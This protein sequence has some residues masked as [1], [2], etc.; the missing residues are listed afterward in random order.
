MK[1][2][3][4]RT[5][6]AAQLLNCSTHVIRRLCESRLV[7][8]ELSHSNQWRVPLSEIE[9]LKEEG[10]PPL[11]QLPAD[12]SPHSP[13]PEKPA[14]ASVPASPTPASMFESDDYEPD[15]VEMSDPVKAELSSLTVAETRLKRRRIEL[16]QEEVED[17]FRERQRREVE[18]QKRERARQEEAATKEARKRWAD[19]WVT[20]AMTQVPVDCPP[21]LRLK[22]FKN[23][24][25]LMSEV[26]MRQGADVLTQIVS[27]AVNEALL[28][29]LRSKEVDRAVEDALSHLPSGARSYPVSRW[30]LTAKKQAYE[31]ISRL[32]ER[33]RF[34]EMVTAARLAIEPTIKEFEHHDAKEALLREMSFWRTWEATSEEREQATRTVRKALDSTDPGCTR[35][36]LQRVKKTALA[37]FE[38]TIS[39]RIEEEKQ[40]RAVEDI[41]NSNL[42]RLSEYLRTD[43]EFK[44]WSDRMVTEQELRPRL[45][46]DLVE[47]ILAGK[48]TRDEVPEYIEEWVDDQLED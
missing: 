36:V 16:Q 25:R 4:Y 33:S 18:E 9:R 34:A 27:A 15:E 41:A 40:R 22:A 32:P 46:D 24:E 2:T 19:S 14:H 12:P 21:D 37:P 10:I 28:P 48:L 11:P 42:Y 30:Q 44:S 31:A 6:Q 38:D 35:E 5:G 43:Y 26:D 47:R 3:T 7:T 1:E 29:Y 17:S 8:A 45:R 23:V 39:A 20:F 13:L